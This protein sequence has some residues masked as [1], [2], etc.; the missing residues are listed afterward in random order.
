MSLMFQSKNLLFITLGFQIT[1]DFVWNSQTGSPLIYHKFCQK[2]ILIPMTKIE[3]KLPMVE[4][5]SVP[6]LP[7][8]K[9]LLEHL[10]SKHSLSIHFSHSIYPYHKLFPLKRLK[11]IS[12]QWFPVGVLTDSI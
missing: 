2:T 7:K 5:Y 9:Y 10:V 6:D 11:V 8:Q 1:N 3:K 12:E 4:E